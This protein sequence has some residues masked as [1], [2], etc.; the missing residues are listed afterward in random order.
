ML[1]DMSIELHTDHPGGN[2]LLME[3]E[4]G[5]PPVVRFAAEPKNCPEALWFH[6]RLTGLDGQAVRIVLANPEQ[7]LGGGDWSTNRLVWRGDGGRWQRT[8]CPAAI[9]TPSGRTEWAWLLEGCGESVEVAACYPYQP[10]DLQETLSDL[11]GLFK[12]ECIGISGRNNR[13]IRIYNRSN[14]AGRPAVYLTARNHAGEVPGSWVLD[15]L[16]RAAA[17]N[18]QIRNGLTIWAMPFV[19]IDD[20][21][22]GSY[23]KDPYPHDCNR[24]WGPGV[25][26][27]PE[28]RAAAEDL[29]TL[30]RQT[31]VAFFCDLHAPSHR[32]QNVYVPLRGWD[33]DSV[34]SQQ[35][36]CF[37]DQFAAHCPDHLRSERPHVTPPKGHSRH[38]GLSASRWARDVMGL[39]A[40]C[41]EISYQGMGGTVFTPEEYHRLGRALLETL[42]DW[43]RGQK[44]ADL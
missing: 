44:G 25:A 8:S 3:V 22:E 10:A 35:A 21:V 4:G 30:I 19:D 12:S 23:G 34:V 20:V 11:D 14:D 18:D 31:R 5:D 39:D 17:E 15:G 7:T 26:A 42:Y 43:A 33:Q 40:A 13:V 24:S 2:G 6:F 16:L 9:H 38:Q 1:L 32:E 37:A 27:R 28:V 41:L 29:H 36:R